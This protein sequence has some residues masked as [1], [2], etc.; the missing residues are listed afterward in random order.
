MTR[1]A[2]TDPGPATVATVAAIAAVAAVAIVTGHPVAAIAPA[3]IAAA[4]TW[5]RT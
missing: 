4:V 2:R 5:W 1:R 3:W